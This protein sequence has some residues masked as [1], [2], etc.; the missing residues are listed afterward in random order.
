M[1][2]LTAEKFD[3][4]AY[5]Q[6][7]CQSQAP[8]QPSGSQAGPT[9]SLQLI[10]R[11]GIGLADPI[12]AVGGPG[13]CSGLPAVQHDAQEPLTELGPGFRLR[14]QRT[15]NHMPPAGRVR[16]FAFFHLLRTG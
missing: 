5:W 1:P 16:K 7:I 9:V 10:D 11:S 4:K 14:G 3:G 12:I 8:G 6:K 2:Y 15:E 13:K